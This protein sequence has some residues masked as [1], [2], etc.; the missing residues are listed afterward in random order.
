MFTVTE[1]GADE[2]P[3]FETEYVPVVFTDILCEVAPL[4]QI[5]EDAALLVNV[6]E[7]PGHNVIGP[8]G[9]IID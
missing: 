7:P 3:K 5:F 1:T 6:A 9:L 2:H 8:E 4:L